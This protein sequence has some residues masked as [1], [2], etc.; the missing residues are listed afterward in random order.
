M[1]KIMNR[2]L[3]SIACLTIILAAFAFFQTHACASPTF[4]LDP[5]GG[6]I[7][8]LPG[9]TVGW[10]FTLTNDSNDILVVSS[11]EFQPFSVPIGTFTDFMSLQFISLDPGTSLTQ[12]FNPVLWQ[13]VGS[14]AIDRSAFVPST[15]AGRILLTYDLFTLDWEQVSFS[16]I[17][18]ADASVSAVPEPLSILLVFPAMLGLAEFRK[19]FICA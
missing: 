15:V 7:S 1:G 19:R 5:A 2:I 3:K 18:T 12:A 13:G 6:S 9:Q 16:N 10:G 4:T 17:L 8:G 14:F 11:A